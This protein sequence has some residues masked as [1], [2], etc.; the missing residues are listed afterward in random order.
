MLNVSSNTSITII[1][2]VTCVRFCDDTIHMWLTLGKKYAVLREFRARE[3]DHAP[4]GT[5]LSVMVKCDRGCVC[6]LSIHHFE[7]NAC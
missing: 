6:C 3:C 2:T 7:P 4:T 1:N 5:L